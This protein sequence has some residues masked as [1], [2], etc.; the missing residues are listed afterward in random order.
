VGVEK[1]ND[2]LEM[3]AWP[4]ALTLSGKR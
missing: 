1:E 3:K 2:N 4:K